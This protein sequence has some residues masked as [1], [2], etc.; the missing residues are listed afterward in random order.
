MIPP[1]RVQQL[2]RVSHLRNVPDG[3]LFLTCVLTQTSGGDEI[4]SGDGSASDASDAYDGAA[5]ESLDDVPDE[6]APPGPRKL[7]AP[8]SKRNSIG[9]GRSKSDTKV[10]SLCTA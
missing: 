10:S 2:S 9:G 6:L 8:T 5:S 4:A 1:E 7:P 3:S